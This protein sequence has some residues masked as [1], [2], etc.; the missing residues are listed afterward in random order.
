MYFHF[1]TP[2]E[3]SPRIYFNVFSELSYSSAD[4]FCRFSIFFVK[5]YSLFPLIFGNKEYFSRKNFENRQKL[6]AK[7]YESS[8]KFLK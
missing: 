3:H 6:S 1:Q 5:R 2:A 8:E 4:N 7:K